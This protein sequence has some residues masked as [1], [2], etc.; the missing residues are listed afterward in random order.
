MPEGAKNAELGSISFRV[1]PL[2]TDEESQELFEANLP[3]SGL[4]PLRVEILHN[5]GAPVDLRGVRFRLRDGAGAEWKLVSSKSAIARILKA[6]GIYVYNP[7]SRKTFEKEFRAYELDLQSPLT[8]AE[9]RRQGFVFF[10]SPKKEGLASPQG[11]VLSVVGL[12][13]AVEMRLN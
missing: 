11:L 7:R 9:R 13:Q 12:P 10:Q 8:H 3:L 6:N 4:L 5:S 2:L 1:A